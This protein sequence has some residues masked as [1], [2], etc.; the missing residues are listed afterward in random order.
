MDTGSSINAI[1]LTTLHK[2]YPEPPPLIPTTR[3]FQSVSKNTVRPL[4]KLLLSFCIDD[5]QTAATFYVFDSL[6]HNFILGIPF[7]MQHR[8]LINFDNH[9]M[10]LA[11]ENINVFVNQQVDIPA[12]STVLIPG[13]LA[14]TN[15]V[16][17]GLHGILAPAADTLADIVLIPSA[18]T[19]QMD[20]VP[21]ML[22]NNN[23]TTTHLTA[24]TLI[25]TFTPIQED[26]V[27]SCSANASCS[28]P[29]N[30]SSMDG[31]PDNASSMDGRHVHTT[32]A[33]SDQSFNIAIKDEP[34]YTSR[35]QHLLQRHDAAFMKEGDHLGAAKLPP[36]HIKLKPG[37]EPKHFSQY[38]YHPEVRQRMQA[39]IDQMLQQGIIEVSSHI[40]WV[41]PLIPIKKG[42]K[43]SRRHLQKPT[44]D[45]DIRPI[46]DL[47]G[48][49][50]ACIY[51]RWS[52][53][54]VQSVIDMIAERKGQ[55]FS[56]L[57]LRQGYFQIPLHKDSRP[58]C[59]FHFNNKG[60]RF[61]V[62]PQGI[63][64]APAQFTKIMAT[65]LKDHLGKCA[66]AYLDDILVF[67]KN[68]EQHL[69]DLDGVL[70]S[71]TESG[72]KLSK[73]KCIFATTTCDYLGHTITP[74]GI[75]P[76]KDH[77]EAI[78]T[79]PAPTKPKE[80]KSFLGICGYFATYIPNKGE[81]VAPLLALLKKNAKWEWSSLCEA[82][83]NKLKAILASRPLLHYADHNK[84]FHLFTDSSGFAISG[85]LMQEDRDGHLVPIAYCGR[86]LTDTER[87]RDIL[88][89]EILA[90]CY[91][92]TQFD[93]YLSFNQFTLY[94]DNNS[95]TKI[96]SNEKRLTPKLARWA[97][98][99]SAYDYTIQHIKG[100][101]NVLADALSRRSYATQHTPADVKIDQF[102]LMPA[103]ICAVTRA[104]KR[105]QTSTLS[106]HVADQPENNSGVNS[107]TLPP[108]SIPEVEAAAPPSPT[109]ITKTVT[110]DLPQ[111]T[112]TR[113]TPF[114]QGFS[115]R[116]FYDAQQ[117][118]TPCKELMTYLKTRIPP[119]N[120]KRAL[121]V[122]LKAP[123]HCLLGEPPLL[124][125]VSSS[126]KAD[127]KPQLRIVVPP[128]LQLSVI[129]TMH[130]TQLATHLGYI[131]C[132]DLIKR[133]FVWRGM[134]RMVHT[135]VANCVTCNKN[136]SSLPTQKAPATPVL[137][138][139]TPFV[140]VGADF[141]GKFAMTQKKHLYIAVVADYTSRLI[142]TWPTK[143]TSAAEFA[144]GFITHVLAIHGCPT[145]LISDRG[146]NFIADVWKETARLADIKISHSSPFLPRSNGRTERMNKVIT[147]ILRCMCERNPRTWDEV[148]PI[149]TFNINNTKTR[150]TGLSPHQIIYG[151]NLRQILDPSPPPIT[152]LAQHNTDLVYAQREA[153]AIINQHNLNMMRDHIPPTSSS[154]LKAGD[155]CFWRR[156]ALDDPTSNKK[157]QVINRGPYR[158]L[159]CTPHQVY[160]QDVT[161]NRPLKNPVSI[162]HIVR[163]ALFHNNS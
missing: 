15:V 87:K 71:I 150:A 145:E 72:L 161:T 57:D 141:L 93:Y 158:V 123:S 75:Q 152:T 14:S 130:D 105:G 56:V 120:R 42:L 90:V 1:S 7:M 64:Q 26:D 24:G 73:S 94:V 131:K 60:Y 99:I 153:M 41:S 104:S 146:P 31:R 37:A 138:P 91:A 23:V 112:A 65:V 111:S 49:N 25:A 142:V 67:S 117:A 113:T 38:R 119:L 47:R 43:R 29:D 6:N 159:R 148:L 98:L 136:K 48:L 5:I 20:T 54:S 162:N 70:T 157:L 132:L 89:G 13:R 52:I 97:L 55:I 22:T 125:H 151:R 66:T 154:A 95:L 33:H 144:K 18:S 12:K 9:T 46:I 21:V 35:L 61:K 10:A 36:M 103:D 4:G 163:P 45:F 27:L 77:T 16:P 128:D 39:K 133:S 80:L 51:G 63:A 129:K 34:V 155:I 134:D 92:L 114:I 101:K 121:Q 32:N 106:Q 3:V 137:S 58:L 139:T 68:K 78:T 96:L 82:N 69:N 85:A 74:T 140:R 110:F 53:P 81:L 62:C 8:A 108:T 122:K 109:K 76:S 44:D 147:N 143:T 156:A 100:T 83:F 149:I 17:S 102:P 19:T 107:P 79:F 127:T 28:S 118:D 59:G 2:L 88:E 84:R 50:S 135:Y 30:A 40:T 126:H 124:Y 116:D 11:A 160:L 86:S 115:P